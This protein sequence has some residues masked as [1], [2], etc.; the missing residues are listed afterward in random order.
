ML[1]ALCGIELIKDVFFLFAIS[2]VYD[3]VAGI[4]STSKNA[5]FG[6]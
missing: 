3:S 1:E 2:F 6:W 5:M 4:F